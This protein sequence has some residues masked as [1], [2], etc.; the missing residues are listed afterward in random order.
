MGRVVVSVAF[1]LI[2][3]AGLARCALRPLVRLA[4]GDLEDA[5]PVCRKSV[6]GGRCRKGILV[7]WPPIAAP[8]RRL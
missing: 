6:F 4:V 8:G 7:D 2:I 1:D 3:S 5:A